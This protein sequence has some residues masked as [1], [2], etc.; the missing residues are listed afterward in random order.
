MNELSTSYVDAVFSGNRKYT[1]TTNSDSTISLED[2]TTYTQEGTAFGAS[3]VN[4]ITGAINSIIGVLPS[5]TGVSIT[6]GSWTASGNAYYKDFTVSGIT[7][8]DTPIVSLYIPNTTAKATAKTYQKMYSYINNIVTYAN[9][10]RVYCH[11][12]PTTA[13]SILI[14]GV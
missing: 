3:D 14:K 6:T 1:M 7:A 11:T 10:I 13:F 8:T 2:S 12:V 5:S 9:K 4:A